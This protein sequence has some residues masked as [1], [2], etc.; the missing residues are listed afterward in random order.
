M[1]LRRMEEDQTL[2]LQR[3]VSPSLRP[4]LVW[5]WKKAETSE[6]DFLFFVNVAESQAE[7]IRQIFFVSFYGKNICFSAVWPWHSVFFSSLCL[8]FC[9]FLKRVIA[10][11][12]KRQQH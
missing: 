1:Q 5:I 10:N 12:W 8:L 4:S 2:H 11:G 7:T 9:Y 3:S 6:C